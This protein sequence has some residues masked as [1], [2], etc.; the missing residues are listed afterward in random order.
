MSGPV[1]ELRGVS[2][3]YYRRGAASL[4]AVDHVNLEV[5]AGECLALVGESGSGKSTLARIALCLIEPDEGEVVLHGTS[6]R[7]LSARELLR[8]RR[9]IQ[10]VFQDPSA[11]FN[12]R[13]TVRAILLQALDRRGDNPTDEATIRSALENVELKPAGDYLGRF[14]HELSGGQRQRLAIARA[15]IPAPTVI[16]ADEPLSGADVSI[17]AQLLNLMVDLQM[18]AN[19][20]YLL[21]THD[22]AVAGAISNRIAV[23][24]RGRIVEEGVTGGVLGSPAHPYT[25]RLVAAAQSG[26]TY[27]DA[28]VRQNDLKLVESGGCAFFARCPLAAPICADVVPQLRPLRAGQNVACH[29]VECPPL[30]EPLRAAPAVG[31]P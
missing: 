27:S 22:M 5:S 6:S 8:A 3:T 30:I 9:T 12:P 31:S 19:L 24:Y 26:G 25:Q 28:S 18:G 4:R 23:M 16:V 14:P 7:N 17:R 21:I 10:P 13:R 11:A 15:L 29:Q 2:K 20:A 1:L